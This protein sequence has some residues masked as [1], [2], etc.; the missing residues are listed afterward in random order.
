MIGGILVLVH[1]GDRRLVQPARLIELPQSL[2]LI[3]EG[4]RLLQSPFSLG[5]ATM[6]SRLTGLS[7]SDDRFYM[8]LAI[9]EARKAKEEG[10]VP[11]GAI[12][13]KDRR[14]IGV[15]HNRPI[16]LVDPTAHAE[17][18]ALRQAASRLGNYRLPATTL[19]VT[20][21]PCAMCAGSLIHARISRLVYGTR[22][23]RAGAVETHFQIVTERALNH[24]VEV[25]SGV[26]E[27]ECRSLLQ[28]FFQERRLRPTLSP[29]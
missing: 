23:L 4:W 27:D 24:R 7:E 22:D 20:V 21:E 2:E 28:R 18:L 25:T 11:V 8:Q 13:V 14:I 16:A 29:D 1:C 17:I 26:L 3:D 9:A 15:G 5:R 19:Y 6:N 10:E 12:L